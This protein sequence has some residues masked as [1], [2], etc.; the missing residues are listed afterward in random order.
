MKEYLSKF[1]KYLT[2]DMWRIQKVGLSRPHLIIVNILRILYLAVK[3]FIYDKC[4][5]K[6]S[7]LTFYSLMSI[8]PLVAM[9]YGIASGFGFDDVLKTELEKNMVGQEKV[10]EYILELSDAYLKN[11]K[12][13]VIIGVGL[14]LLFWS[15][16]NVLGNIEQSFN[17]IWEIKRSRNF[18]RKF[19]DYIALV[20][21]AFLF[22]VSSSSMVL[23]VSGKFN[24]YAALNYIG[25]S[26]SL[27]L[28]YFLICIVFTMLILI[29]PNTKV[30]FLSAIVGGLVA[31][32]LFQLLQ[33]FFINF[34]VGVSRTSAIYGS[35]AALPLFLI[36]MQSSWLIVMFG[37]EISF[38]VQNA[39]S[40]EFEADTKNVCIEY[41]RIVALLI[42][43]N[44]IKRFE[45]GIAPLTALELSKEL[46]MPIR[47]VNEMLFDLLKSKII[48]EV[49]VDASSV[50]AYQPAS[51]INKL[52]VSTI[53]NMLETTG[54]NELH[55]EETESLRKVKQVVERFKE[56]RTTS[57]NNILLKDL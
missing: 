46:R 9:L 30:N 14:I 50:T 19:T 43:Y 55:F 29:M 15:V 18:A 42:S 5:Q 13:G 7:A 35:F 39:S 21:V 20:I 1:I 31:G 33:Y 54:S 17:D 12:S 52:Q 47:L 37:A 10:L 16:M 11:T 40:F 38:A 48:I 2:E 53:L 22:L 23:F 36:W 3:G 44:T 26:V 4:Q 6:A 41:K 34:M 51:D 24:D 49:S 8:V 57:S 28:P 25:K 56:N 32:I 27:M 45:E